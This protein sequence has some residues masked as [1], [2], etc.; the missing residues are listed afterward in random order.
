MVGLQAQQ[1]YADPVCD[2]IHRH[3][4]NRIDQQDGGVDHREVDPAQDRDQAGQEHMHRQGHEHD[5][6]A[7]AKGGCDGAS[8]RDPDLGVGNAM[9]EY[10]A[11]KAE[12]PASLQ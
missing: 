2:V 10:A 1:H 12:R 11:E 7:H 4:R 3:D 6:Q 8:V 5:G 9:P